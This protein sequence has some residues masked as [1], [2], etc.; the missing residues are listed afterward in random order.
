[1]GG[2]LFVPLLPKHACR[3]TFREMRDLSFTLFSV[4]FEVGRE[5]IYALLQTFKSLFHLDLY[6]IPF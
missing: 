4:D 2:G 1:M 3:N 5:R 6:Q